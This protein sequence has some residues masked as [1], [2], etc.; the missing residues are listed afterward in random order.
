MEINKVDIQQISINA[1]WSIALFITS[2]VSNILLS[3]FYTN[4]LGP[5]LYGEYKIIVM[6]FTIIDQSTNFICGASIL[7]YSSIQENQIAKTSKNYF[8][9]AL[10]SLLFI[11]VLIYLIY[12]N[13]SGLFLI[14]IYDLEIINNSKIYFIQLLVQPFN[15]IFMAYNISIYK[16]KR[17]FIISSLI[18]IF[19]LIFTVLM[20]FLI[21]ISVFNLIISILSANVLVC[22][23]WIYIIIK[24]KMVNRVILKDLYYF[25]KLFV[26]SVPFYIYTLFFLLVNWADV[27]T[28]SIF[29]KDNSKY[30]VGIYS[31]ARSTYLLVV[32]LMDSIIGTLT[33]AYINIYLKG[34][35]EDLQNSIDKSTKYISI[36]SIFFSSFFITIG[37]ILVLTIY[38][39]YESSIPILQIFLIEIPSGSI[40][41]MLNK[42]IVASEQKIVYK[43]IL[44]PLIQALIIIGLIFFMVFYLNLGLYGIVI[45]VVIGRIAGVF[46]EYI[47]I[48]RMFKIKIKFKYFIKP[49][50]SA[51]ISIAIIG[52]LIYFFNILDIMRISNLITKGIILMIYSGIYIS[53]LSIL[54]ILIRTFDEYDYSNY[55]EFCEKNKLLKIIGAPIG[56]LLKKFQQ[57]KE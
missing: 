25:K 48:R 31:V 34:N 46:Y 15:Y 4:L 28:I 9:M 2:N 57:N 47:F 56:Y 42:L 14:N 1:F 24:D 49:L 35:L 33:P 41:L 22:G 30:Y 36:L 27:F 8:K 18:P 45:S 16:I 43:S 6:I 10:I 44:I 55:V 40:G 32:G 21:S 37:P 5:E 53:I 11:K 50:I 38:P 3:I 54:L 39:A 19:S 26:F 12:F 23:I 29:F 52:G 20:F 17:T 7:K 13:I 51:L